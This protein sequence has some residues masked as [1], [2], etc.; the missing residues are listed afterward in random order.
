VLASADFCYLP[1][2]TT[3]DLAAGA[4]IEIFGYQ[5]SGAGLALSTAAGGTYLRARC[6][7]S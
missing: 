4:V 3:E 1:V 2:R 6:T 5:T 7:G